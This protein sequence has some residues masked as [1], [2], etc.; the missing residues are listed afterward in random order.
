MS[1]REE[2]KRRIV[3]PWKHTER[4]RNYQRRVLA[5]QERGEYTPPGSPGGASKHQ[6]GPQG[7]DFEEE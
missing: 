6:N 7:L 2:K 3:H 5:A 4:D 1:D